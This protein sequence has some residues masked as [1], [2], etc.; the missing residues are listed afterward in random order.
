MKREREE[1]EEGGGRGRVKGKGGEEEGGEGMQSI[2]HYVLFTN[3][4]IHRH[5]YLQ[6]RYYRM[7]PQNNAAFHLIHTLHAVHVSCIRIQR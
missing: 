2:Y 1:R 4:H 3:S 7:L 6:Y 5:V